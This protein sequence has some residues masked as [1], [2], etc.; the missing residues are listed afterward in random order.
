LET[1][2]RRE[3]YE[4]S[5]VQLIEVRQIGTLHAD[6]GLIENGIDVMYG[7]VDG[8]FIDRAGHQTEAMESIGPLVWLNS[9]QLR[10]LLR[11]GAISCAITIAAL[12]IADELTPLGE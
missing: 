9:Q 5:G 2:A 4:E 6:T 11:D 7:T 12:T 1:A 10:R 3:A 8:S